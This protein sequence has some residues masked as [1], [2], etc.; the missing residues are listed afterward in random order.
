MVAAAMHTKIRSKRDPTNQE[1]QHVEP[2]SDHHKHRRNGKVLFDR[3]HD[4]IEQGEHAKDRHKDNIVHDRG[5]AARGRC[6]HVAGEGHDEKGPE[7]L[8]AQGGQ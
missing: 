5:I 1:E 7:E 8:Y 2:I 4:E 6:D 3:C